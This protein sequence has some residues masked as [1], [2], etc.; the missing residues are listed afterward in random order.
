MSKIHL[1][2]LRIQ[3][4]LW[5]ILPGII[6][7]IAFSLTG[8]G[9]HEQSMRTLVAGENLRLADAVATTIATRID[10]Y[11]THLELMAGAPA[12]YPTLKELDVWR[13]IQNQPATEQPPDWA[14]AAVASATAPVTGTQVTVDANTSRIVWLVP[15]RGQEG[16]LV[17]SVPVAALGLGE[18]MAP[19]HPDATT[20]FALVGAPGRIIHGVGQLPAAGEVAAWSGVAPGLNG[21]SGTLVDTL[22]GEAMIVAYT[23]VA[24]TPWALVIRE[25][26]NAL[27]APLFHFESLLPLIMA[28]A[29]IISFF[30]LYF[31]LR[32]IARPLQSLALQANRIGQGEF[33]AAAEPVG[34]LEEIEDL[35]QALHAMAQ[36]LQVNQAAMR[37]YVHAVTA[38]QE[39]ERARL[40]RELHDETVQTLIALDHKAQMVQRSLNRNPER[41]SNQMADLRHMIAGATQDVRRF[42]QALRPPYLADLGLAPALEMLAREAGAELCVS[43]AERRLSEDLELALYRIAQEA[44]NNVLRHAHA[45]TIRVALHFGLTGVTLAI[46]DDGVGFIIPDKL[47]ELTKAGHFG[48]MGMRERTDLVGGQLRVKSRPG[49]GTDVIVQ[50]PYNDYGPLNA[51]EWKGDGL[52][53]WLLAGRR[54]PQ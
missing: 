52:E 2:R 20:T 54:Q 49:E 18:L 23:P 40:A 51:A 46:H 1:R 3:V 6:F 29:A 48:L 39:D 17:G 8:S 34:G 22:G 44:L 7:L 28:A 30:T 35:R 43:G 13:I 4:L 15:L 5:T 31:G 9:G 45:Q 19:F 12:A 41:S 11:T 32:Y 14:T 33:D 24:G 37:D 27:L 36:R 47:T 16:W 26:L 42:T 53:A 25:P 21:A 10:H 38:A 50:S